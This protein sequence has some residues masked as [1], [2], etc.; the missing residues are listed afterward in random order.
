VAQKKLRTFIM[1]YTKKTKKS[2]NIFHTKFS[3]IQSNMQY[4]YVLRVHL[5][6]IVDVNRIFFIMN[7]AKVS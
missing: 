3:S 7:L 5:F 2:T 1:A 6:S 4:S